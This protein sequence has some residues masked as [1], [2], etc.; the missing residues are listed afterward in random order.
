MRKHK[1]IYYV[2]GIIS[3]LLVPLLFLYYATPVYYQMSMRVLDIGLPY[4][5]KEGEKIPEY[6]QIPKE[7]WSYKTINVKPGFEAKTEE[8]FIKEINRLKENNVD[9]T[10]IRFQLSDKNVYA[11]IIG[12]LNIMLKTKQERYGLDMEGTNSL[13]VLYKKPLEYTTVFGC[14]GGDAGYLSIDEYNYDNANFWNRL[15]YYS[16]K[17]SYYLIFGFLMLI[18]CAML[19][20]KL[21][22]NI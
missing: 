7:G 1:K 8:I 19:R 21:S 11:D 12:L 4:K 2:A 3:A 5:A 17:E 15:I 13:Y 20:P 9:Q 16:P 18:Y 10:G 6:T 22:F 14:G